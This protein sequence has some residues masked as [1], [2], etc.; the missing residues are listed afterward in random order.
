MNELFG[1][2]TLR[3]SFAG[4][5]MQVYLEK[6]I[7]TDVLSHEEIAKYSYKLADAMLEAKDSCEC[8]IKPDIRQNEILS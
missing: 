4:L 7:G 5:A 8:V 2:I 6:N 3:D 1:G